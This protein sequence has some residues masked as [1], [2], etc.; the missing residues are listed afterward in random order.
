MWPTP[1]KQGTSRKADASE[2]TCTVYQETLCIQSDRTLT[3]SISLQ[4]HTHYCS[5]AFMSDSF[6]N[7]SSKVSLSYWRGVPQLLDRKARIVSA[8]NSLHCWF[9]KWG[10][11][12][13]D[14]FLSFSE[15]VIYVTF[16][17]INHPI[18]CKHKIWAM[19]RFSV[20]SWWFKVCVNTRKQYI[21]VGYSMVLDNQC[22]LYGFLGW[23]NST[24]L[25]GNCHVL[26]P[27]SSINKW[28]NEQEKD[29]FV[30]F[31]WNSIEIIC[32]H[33]DKIIWAYGLKR[34]TVDMSVHPGTII[35]I[36]PYVQLDLN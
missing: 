27:K 5:C 7:S 17:D 9:L 25:Y 15:Q 13:W 4:R 33:T 20:F 28:L 32:K 26:A 30:L 1:A 18:C 31:F 6:Y 19:E 24:N 3:I 29:L 8:K 10:T 36:S 11:C 35:L 2:F 23:A 14:M 16:S 21:H 22:S 12:R 34:S